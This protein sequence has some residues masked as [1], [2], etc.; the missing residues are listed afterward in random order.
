MTITN[1]RIDG[2][3]LILTLADPA[4]A[5]KLVYRFKAGEYE[6]SPVRKKRSLEANAYAWVMINRIAER[7]HE[8]PV[9]IYRRYIRDIGGKRVVSCVKQED[10]E[11]EVKT[12]TAGHIGRLVN[13]GTS[14]IPGCAT[15]EKIYG[16]S[17]YDVEQMSALIDAIVQDCDALGIETKTQEEIEILLRR[18]RE[19]R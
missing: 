2:N 1:A 8:P 14:K 17:D 13:I 15:V 10:L 6:I 3:E 7:I 4:D 19:S 18:W 9:E 11:T 12:F 16:S 5:G